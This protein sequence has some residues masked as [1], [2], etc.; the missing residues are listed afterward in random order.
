MLKTI[1]IGTYSM[2]Q[3]QFVKTLSDGRLV[4][5]VGDRLHVGWPVKRDMAA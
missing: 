2:V 4:V 1:M 3:G 5:R